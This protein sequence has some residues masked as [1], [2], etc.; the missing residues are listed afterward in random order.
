MKRI[1]AM[2][3][4]ASTL[5][6]S[7]LIASPAV[8]QPPSAPSGAPQHPAPVSPG[9]PPV[10][11][12]PGTAPQPPQAPAQ[13]VPTQPA[14]PAPAPLP[15]P[16]QT[17]PAPPPTAKRQPEPT[18]H[19]AAIAAINQARLPR[20]IRPHYFY[21]AVLRAEILLDRA[22]FSPGEI[23]GRYGDN[24]AKALA[25]YQATHRLP[26]TGRLDAAT[27][28]ALT[29]HDTAP[30]I[31]PYQLTQANITGPF[32]RSIPAKLDEQATLP[33]TCYTSVF[34]KLGE[35]F[36]VNPRVLKKLNPHALF[37][38]AGETVNVPIVH[39]YP[40]AKRAAM[41]V[42]TQHSKTV[43]A[44][45]ADGHVLAQY[46]ATIGSFHDPLPIGRWKIKGVSRHPKFHYNPNLFWDAKDTDV[47]AV[48]PPGPNNPVGVVW[49]QLSNPHYGIHGTPEP[50]RIG[51]TYSHGCI[52]LTNWDAWELSQ[53]VRP[54]TPALLQR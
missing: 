24:M 40:P 31:G 10:V 52:R 38:Q 6:A 47:K 41:V 48:I 18:Q 53:M 14:Q 12:M 27:W 2:L 54:G 15:R 28:Q 51:K 43:T 44:L 33:C 13:A 9:L 49:I 39:R 29:S 20:H 7:G 4:A 11:P 42:V 23:D 17:Q 45:D 8:A 50:A 34:E 37:N 46:P 1:F 5:A 3:L 25:G 35:T 22:H 16:A 32:I 36:H 30:V 21:N 19:L 26:V